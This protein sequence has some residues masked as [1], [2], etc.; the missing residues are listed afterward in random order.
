VGL[1]EH[2]TWRKKVGGISFA[3]FM[4]IV[5]L[6]AL[7][8][9]MLVGI[10]LA[11]RLQFVR[12]TTTA[13]VDALTLTQTSGALEMETNTPE[14]S[15]LA[16][17]LTQTAAVL[18]Q[19]PTDTATPPRLPALPATPN[20]KGQLNLFNHWRQHPELAAGSMF[21]KDGAVDQWITNPETLWLNENEGLWA[22]QGA[23]VQF[24]P[25]QTPE[26]TMIGLR[27]TSLSGAGGQEFIELTRDITNKKFKISGSMPPGCMMW[28][29]TLPYLPEQSYG[30]QISV[31][32]QNSLKFLISMVDEDK[33][34]ACDTERQMQTPVKLELYFKRRAGVF[35]MMFPYITLLLPKTR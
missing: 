10:V 19:A 33:V 5:A 6:A 20:A 9:C 15:W 25:R 35:Q 13:P 11:N 17:G 28:G 3:F 18:T 26:A 23:F 22:Y 31:V 27:M 4:A 29:V 2:N 12:A 7:A 14:S 24:I 30:M 21:I 1:D 16:A 8:P 34:Y 32:D